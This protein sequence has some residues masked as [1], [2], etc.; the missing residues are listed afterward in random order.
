MRFGTI[1]AAAS[2]L[3][4]LAALALTSSPAFAVTFSCDDLGSLRS[5]AGDQQVTLTFVNDTDTQRVLDWIDY[6]G[7]RVHYA[8]IAPG[9]RHRQQTFL[10]HPWI[11]STGPG[12]CLGILVAD[13]SAIINLSDLS[14]IS[15]D[16]PSLSLPTGKIIYRCGSLGAIEAVFNENVVILDPV[17]G[18]Q[19]VLEQQ[20]DF[21]GPN[22]Q[23]RFMNGD[24]A[25]SR[26]P[27]S[28]PE[29]GDQFAVLE[30]PDFGKVECEAR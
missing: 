14:A 26:D 6:D 9:Q 29:E 11:I 24:Y 30:I 22:G 2:A 17:E 10:T 27:E 3:I 20:V 8:M 1:G 23:W 25:F 4:A 5:T 28:E 12:D 13:G 7:N 21:T 15:E 19:M 16:P 18:N